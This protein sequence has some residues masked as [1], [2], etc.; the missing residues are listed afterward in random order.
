MF[1]IP[2]FPETLSPNGTKVADF[3]LIYIEI[4]GLKTQRWIPD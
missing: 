2:C 4:I 1:K 3:T